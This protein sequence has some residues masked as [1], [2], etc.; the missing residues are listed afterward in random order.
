MDNLRF[1]RYQINGKLSR[2]KYAIKKINNAK[3]LIPSPSE[4]EIIKLM[5]RH[6]EEDVH[7]V[8]VLG[9]VQDI[10]SLLKLLEE[11]DCTETPGR[12]TTIISTDNQI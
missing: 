2:V 7:R 11:I 10:Q 4:T 9:L 8:V 3:S 12:K 5:S 6:F 1:G